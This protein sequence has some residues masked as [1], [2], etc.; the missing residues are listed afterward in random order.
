M[1]SDDVM[2]AVFPALAAC[3]DNATGPREIPDHVLVRQTLD[4][5]LREAMDIDGLE[6]L[7]TQLAD[8]EVRVHFRDTT[9]PSPLSHEILNSRPYTFLDDAPLEER[10]TRAVQL[11]RGLPVQGR[12]LA[13]LD[14]A[15]IDRVRAEAAPDPRDA[16]ELLDVLLWLGAVAP[17][18]EWQA[19]F[20]ELAV[21]Q[22][23]LC[24]DVHG[25]PLWCALEKRALLEVLFPA[26]RF[27][28]DHA[29]PPALAA[30]P[31]P[32]REQAAHD[33]VRGHLDTRGPSTL[34]DLCE[35]TALDGDA[36]QYA[37]GQLEGE[38]LAMRGRFDPRTVEEEW[39]ARRLLGR[40]HAYTQERLRRD[41]EPVT[42]QDFVRFLLRWQHVEPGRQRSGQAGLLR[43]IAQLQG[44][45]LA[46]G[47]WERN[48]LSARIESYRPEWLD[49]LCLSGQVTWGR[50][51]RPAQRA[52]S[53]EPARAATLSRATPIT[54]AIRSDWQWLARGMGEAEERDPL[55]AGTEQVL[56]CLRERGALFFTELRSCSGLSEDA[57]RQ[58]LWDG[59]ARGLITADGFGALRNLLSPS[60]RW[61]SARELEVHRSG[62]RRGA[63]GAQPGEGRWA[64][65]TPQAAVLDGDAD[66]DGLA[67]AVAEQLLARWG[68][69][70]RDLMARES[71]PIAWR[72]VT[73]AL[74]RLEARG[75]V[76]GGRFVTGFSGEQYALPDAV[77]MLR[78]V[79]REG[80]GAGVLVRVSGCDP[81]NLAGVV[82]PGPRVPA[83][84]TQTVMYRDG[85]IVEAVPGATAEL[86]AGVA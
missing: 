7:L 2:V 53:G 47:A 24:A 67:E 23:A 3:Q 27:S 31:R 22:R 38:G 28:P 63:R 86:S 59:V 68:V 73:W 43:V 49:G 57:L 1:E 14:P 32:E 10:R 12:E 19:W 65:V 83:V 4:D 84:R 46:A 44:F 35:A 50:L 11:R 61:R 58:A 42:V 40:I 54:I 66:P 80:R 26:A 6:R 20:D 18:A 30:Q 78:S 9:E 48:V 76:R 37:L 77:D 21:A 72:D 25:R 81:L 16:G 29:L 74:R 17:N 82:L 70:F 45:E 55:E 51:G 41:I 69:V 64:L 56:A 36:V 79:R 75:L 8:G 15:A 52:D 5:C 33:V 62:L 39:C 85:A 60:A 13:A 71:L 34:R